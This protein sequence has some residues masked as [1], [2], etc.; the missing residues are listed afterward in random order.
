MPTLSV[1]PINSQHYYSS[2]VDK[3]KLSGEHNFEIEETR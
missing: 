2:F 3:F 1:N